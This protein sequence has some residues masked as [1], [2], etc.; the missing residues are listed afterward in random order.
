MIT[1]VEDSHAVRRGDSQVAFH[2]HLPEGLPAQNLVKALWEVIQSRD[3]RVVTHAVVALSQLLSAERA[4]AATAAA[5]W[6]VPQTLVRALLRRLLALATQPMVELV[7]AA[8]TCVYR[9]VSLPSK[10]YSARHMLELVNVPN[11]LPL[12]VRP[13][14]ASLAPVCCG[15]ALSVPHTD[16][17]IPTR[18]I[19]AHPGGARGAA[20]P[21]AH[22]RP[23]GRR[24]PPPPGDARRAAG[25]LSGPPVRAPSSVPGMHTVAQLRLHTTAAR[26]GVGPPT[27]TTAA[28]II[29]DGA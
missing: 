2:L 8:V 20:V 7:E 13:A 28:V 19:I 1:T 17:H 4:A 23:T 10:Q 15:S 14:S 6:V 21:C 5:L 3:P 18:P 25:A 11:A 9:L 26:H 16:P 22:R 27:A 24:A 29:H 12:L